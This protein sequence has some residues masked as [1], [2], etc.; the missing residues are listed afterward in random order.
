M[1]S[2][3]RPRLRAAGGC[4][5]VPANVV[6]VLKAECSMLNAHDRSPMGTRHWALGIVPSY[7]VIT[8]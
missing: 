6:Q 5:V 2:I 8:Q 1:R 3:M 7:I 4:F